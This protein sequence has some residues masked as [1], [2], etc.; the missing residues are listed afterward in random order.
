MFYKVCDL[1][2][3]MLAH[4]GKTILRHDWRNIIQEGS[5][6]QSLAV[7]GAF[8]MRNGQKITQKQEN[9]KIF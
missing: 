8:C 3:N 1:E 7:R 2:K 9:V 5:D 6:P 4:Q